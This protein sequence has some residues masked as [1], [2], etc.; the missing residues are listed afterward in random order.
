MIKIRILKLVI[1]GLSV[2]AIAVVLFTDNRAVRVALSSSTGG[3]VP[4]ERTG[5][6]RSFGQEPTCLAGG[7]HQNGPLAGES[8]NIEVRD[9]TNTQ[10]VS[11]YQPGQNYKI[12]VTHTATGT[13]WG[14]E[15]TAL[16]PTLARAG[17][18]SAADGTTLSDRFSSS[19]EYTNHSSPNTG[20]WT[21]NWTAPSTN[22]GTVNF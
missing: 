5:A 18:M 2:C 13:G 7:C 11:G 22:V 4:L 8:L 1:L 12:N 10:V 16:D 20:N 17:D 19:R 9:V 15:I 21:F 3:S 14:F 6:P